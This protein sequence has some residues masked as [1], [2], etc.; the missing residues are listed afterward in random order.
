MPFSY[1]VILVTMVT[2]QAA[3]MARQLSSHGSQRT[4][5]TILV[6]VKMTPALRK[7][8]K[9]AALDD[10]MTYAQL[11]ERLLDEREEKLSKARAKQ[12]HPFHRPASAYPGGGI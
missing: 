12:A 10:D 8:F 6:P 4:A 3:A 2:H 7:R 1:R 9:Q 5:K 11:I